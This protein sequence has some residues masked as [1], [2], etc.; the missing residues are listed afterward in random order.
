MI[1]SGCASSTT[2]TPIEIN[3]RSVKTTVASRDSNEEHNASQSCGTVNCSG[4]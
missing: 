1:P 4:R 3:Q 2:S